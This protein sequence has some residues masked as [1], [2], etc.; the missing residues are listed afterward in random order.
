METSHAFWSSNQE[1]TEKQEEITKLDQSFENEKFKDRKFAYGTAGFRTN[2][3]ALDRVWFR[4]GVVV[5]AIASEISTSGVVITASHNPGE[6]NGVKICNKDGSMIDRVWEDIL[7]QLINSQSFF[8]DFNEVLEARG[9]RRNDAARVLVACDTRV[10]S[11]RLIDTL[12][13]GIS[14]MGVKCKDFGFLTTPQLHFLV[15]YSFKNLLTP[16]EIDCLTEEV[17]YTYYSKN[18]KEY[19][20]LIH[21]ESPLENYQGYFILDTSNGIGGKKAK[22]LELIVNST[23][24]GSTPVIINDGSDGV[25]RLNDECGAEYVHKERKFSKYTEEIKIDDQTKWVTFD[26]DADRIVYFYKN[27]DS[28][29]ICVVDGDKIAIL[30]GDYIKSLID[31]ISKDGVKLADIITFGVVQTGYA[32]SAAS[33]Y[34]SSK[35][36]T[37]AKSLTGVKNM[38]HKALKFDIGLYFEANGHGTIVSKYD[39]IVE[40]LKEH[41]FDLNNVHIVKFLNFL[42]L[43][44]EAVG[45]AM[46][47]LVM[48]EIYLRDKDL[49]IQMAD[50]VYTD[51]PSKMLKVPVK[52]RD[53]FVTEAD[54]ETILLKPE[55]LQEEILEVWNKITPSRAFVRPSGTEDVVRIYA[56]G[57]TQEDADKV[58][59]Q[60]FEIISSKYNL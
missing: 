33:N 24:Y 49:T 21:R 10:S 16:E 26:G 53:N 3:D 8:H 13:T 18:T 40:I 56:E 37:V 17:Y 38:H 5:A 43:T 41:D 50:K 11:K 42:L 9:I 48:M 30:L 46:A 36:V 34:L 4:V 59:N 29:S 28:N 52:N 14:V 15:W 57:P 54:D 6:D 12:K 25:S 22:K 35:G 23:S 58:S 7:T 60:I 47:I 39:K 32:N 20:K 51:Y 2:A 19:L 1:A 44:N 45:D 27:S 31:D 55:G